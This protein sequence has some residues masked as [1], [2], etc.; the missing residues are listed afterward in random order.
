MNTEIY[1]DGVIN[2]AFNKGMVRIEFGTLSITEKDEN[3]SPKIFS[4]HQLVVTPQVFLETFSNME[5]MLQKL[6][7]NGI[8]QETDASEQRGG[9]ARDM[10]S[11]FSGAD[12]RG[13]SERRKRAYEVRK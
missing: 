8:V 7:D 4:R 6:V 10:E 11:S 12:K 2:I 9:P 1:S 3:G 5:S 13:K